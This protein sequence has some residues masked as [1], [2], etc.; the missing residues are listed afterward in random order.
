MRCGDM[1]AQIDIPAEAAPRFLHVRLPPLP[2]GAYDLDI[3]AL[4]APVVLG[5][6]FYLGEAPTRR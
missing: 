5:D 3:V 6:L 1:E 2:P 4:T